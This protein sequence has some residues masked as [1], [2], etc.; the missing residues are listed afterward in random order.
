M[1]HEK[2]VRNENENMNNRSV[3]KRWK[4]KWLNDVS[5]HANWDQ[6]QAC[7]I[8]KDI[9]ENFDFARKCSWGG[10]WFARGKLRSRIWKTPPEDTRRLGLLI[11]GKWTRKSRPDWIENTKMRWRVENMVLL[12]QDMLGYVCLF[13][14]PIC[15]RNARPSLISNHGWPSSKSWPSGKHNRKIIS[16]RR[17]SP[18]LL[19]LEDWKCRTVLSA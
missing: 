7:I 19:F 11:A 5:C 13:Q 16:L 17:E 2:A 3:T 15:L 1:A 4:T 8:E 10:L 6:G 9:S 18:F 14:S 12:V